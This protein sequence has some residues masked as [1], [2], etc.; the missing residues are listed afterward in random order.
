MS[1]LVAP[2]APPVRGHPD[3]YEPKY[4]YKL[5]ATH[6]LL[7]R[8]LQHVFLDKETIFWGG[9]RSISQS[10]A[11]RVPPEQV[12]PAVRRLMYL[13]K[14]KVITFPRKVKIFQC[15]AEQDCRRPCPVAR[16]RPLPHRSLGAPRLEG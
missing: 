13:Y 1:Q 6:A 11:S 10:V 3:A 15:R 5:W 14:F 16:P 12:R 4:L 2:R 9:A 7:V 8:W